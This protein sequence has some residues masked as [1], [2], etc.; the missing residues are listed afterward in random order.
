M[1]WPWDNPSQQKSSHWCYKIF[2]LKLF[3]TTRS[4]K[5]KWC[6]VDVC[7]EV[8]LHLY[9]GFIMTIPY[10][11]PDSKVHG[12]HLGSVG[13]RWAHVGLMNLAIRDVIVCST[14]ITR[15]EHRYRHKLNSSPPGQN[16]RH[17]AD[18][19]FRCIFVNEKFCIL[20]EISMKFVSNGPIDNNP[21]LV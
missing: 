21:A 10:N 15:A 13:P 6:L 4:K 8:L 12:A 19:I 16:G 18:Q 5:L 14:A 9:W 20:I 3:G 7:F 2:L 17:L 1:K 11:I